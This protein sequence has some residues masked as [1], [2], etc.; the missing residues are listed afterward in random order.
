MHHVSQHCDA[1]CYCGFKRLC[2]RTSFKNILVTMS[3]QH[4]RWLA[5]RFTMDLID[6]GQ[7]VAKE[8]LTSNWINEFD[9]TAVYQALLRSIQSCFR[10]GSLHIQYF[11]SVAYQG[12]SFNNVDSYIA[13][14]T[15]DH[16]QP[17]YGKVYHIIRVGCK[18]APV[19]VFSS[20]GS[21]I[22]G[23]VSLLGAST[24]RCFGCANPPWKSPGARPGTLS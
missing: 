14:H 18:P 13:W 11:K 2:Q 1:L 17:S 3:T 6:I 19:W 4:Q 23:R 20:M 16:W 21:H 22:R 10:P 7:P 9:H 15:Q 12:F 5:Y 24:E 8:L